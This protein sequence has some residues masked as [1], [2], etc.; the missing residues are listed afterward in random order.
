MTDYLCLDITPGVIFRN[1]KVYVSCIGKVNVFTA[2]KA[3]NST[4]ILTRHVQSVSSSSQFGI[5]LE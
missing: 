2:E 1:R 3:N 5:S 4:A